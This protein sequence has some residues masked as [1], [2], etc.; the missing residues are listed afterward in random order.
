MILVIKS[1]TT[2]GEQNKKIKEP[3]NAIMRV[4]ALDWSG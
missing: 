4:E 1:K 3:R 2:I